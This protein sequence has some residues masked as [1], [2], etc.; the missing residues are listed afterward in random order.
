MLAV[1]AGLDALSFSHFQV[2]EPNPASKKRRIN[3][4]SPSLFVPYSK[5]RCYVGH[6]LTL[7]ERFMYGSLF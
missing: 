4:H 7:P 1:M 3:T 2:Y 5:V 6:V